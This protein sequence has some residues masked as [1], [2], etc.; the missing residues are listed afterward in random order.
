[1]SNVHPTHLFPRGSTLDPAALPTEFSS[2]SP[3][4]PAGETPAAGGGVAARHRYDPHAPHHHPWH[5]RAAPPLGALRSIFGSLGEAS[6]PQAQREQVLAQQLSP[7]I[8]AWVEAYTSVGK[9][10]L[11]LWKWCTRG[12]ELTTLPC[13]PP[14]LRAD[15]VD[16]KVL[17]GMLNVLLD[18]AADQQGHAGLLGEL[19]KLVHGAS[20]DWSRLNHEEQAYGRFTRCVW[21]EYWRRVR[22]YPCFAAFKQLLRYDLAQ[23]FNTIHYSY[24]VNRNLSMLNLVEHDQYSAQ[25]MMMMSFATVDLMCTPGFD[26]RELGTLREAVW[27]GQWMARIGNLIS[28]WKRE[29]DEGDYTSGVFA[30]AVALGELSIEQLAKADPG[31]IEGVIRHGG[32]EEHFLARWQYHRSRLDSL[33]PQI[34]SFDLAVWLDG[35]DCLLDTELGSCGW[36]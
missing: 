4:A 6:T 27:H 25:G 12:V 35:L 32:H 30:R 13:V 3:D 15:A 21:R 2:P 24:L 33:R 5:G 10:N 14:D 34:G 36:K 1:M 23:L 18:D 20:P 9:R 28:T 8:A 31:Q 26:V 16:T 11:Y 7:T 29:I 22:R 19:L 17:S